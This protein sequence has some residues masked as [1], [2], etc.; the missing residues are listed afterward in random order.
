MRVCPERLK[1]PPRRLR[2]IWFVEPLAV[3]VEHLIGADDESAAM[4][5]GNTLRLGFRQGF[6]DFIRLQ[7]GCATGMLD[8]I[9]IDLRWMLSNADAGCG[10]HLRARRAAGCKHDGGRASDQAELSAT[11]APAMRRCSIRRISAAVSSIDRRVTSITGQP[12][13]A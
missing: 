2:V 7:P 9:L 12:I 11:G 5:C 6:R 1:M 13:R 10:Q 4:P 8:L 3:E